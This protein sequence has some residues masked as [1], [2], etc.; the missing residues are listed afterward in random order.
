VGYR[1]SQ[2]EVNPPSDDNKISC[3]VSDSHSSYQS[4]DGIGIKD[5][6]DHSVRLALVES[7]FR[8][9]GNDTACILPSMLK[10][11]ESLADLRS[12]VQ[13]GVVK[14]KA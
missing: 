2:N 8:T 10:K 11:S 7:S 4:S 1:T 14:K 12:Y 13:M 9:T 5:I 6:P 3:T